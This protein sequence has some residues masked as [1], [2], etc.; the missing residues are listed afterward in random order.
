MTTETFNGWTNHAT[1]NVSLWI[2]NE[3]WLYNTAKACV[4]YVT[5]DETPYDKFIRCMHN[6][7]REA[8][9]DGVSWA[10]DEVNRDE[11]NAMMTEL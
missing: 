7:D 3:Q 9:K 2:Q 8:T 10:S 5:E 11:I 4:Q 1:W 6:V